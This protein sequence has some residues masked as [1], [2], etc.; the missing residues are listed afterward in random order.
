MRIAILLF[1]QPRYL[2]KTY[3]HILEEF[4]LPDCSVD[5]FGH[6]WERIGFIPEDEHKEELQ[7]I[8]KED[9]ID[10]LP[11]KKLSIKNND[12]LNE[13]SQAMRTMN[14]ILYSNRM[15]WPDK[16]DDFR[17]FI[18]QHYSIKRC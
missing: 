1:G 2:D 15:P 12:K 17:Y 8:R 14:S 3:K 18:G 6:F 4:N 9:L 16:V 5:Y 13:L 7:V 10:L 11:F